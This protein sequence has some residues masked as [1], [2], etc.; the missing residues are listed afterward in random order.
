M[1]KDLRNVK[2]YIYKLTSPNGKIYIGQTINNKKRKYNYKKGGFKSQIKLW[3]SCEKHKWNPVD[4]YEIIEECLCGVNKEY[5]N[6]REKYWIKHYDCFKFGLNCN[7]G[8]HGNIGHKHSDETKKKMSNLAKRYSKEISI[9]MKKLRTG[10]KLSKE[11]K[12]KISKA[13]MGRVTSEET[14][15]K[16]S[17]KLTGR[18]VSEVVRAKIS[19]SKKGEVSNKRKHVYQIGLDGEIIKLWSHAGEAEKELN[20]IRGKISAVCLGKRNKTGGFKWQYKY[21]VDKK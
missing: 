10:S 14:K 16:L 8:G 13:N 20:I 19:E 12:L 5:L 21:D 3:A 17:K 9:R 6:N 15:I 2:G 11:T 1:K 7:E 4:T 18:I